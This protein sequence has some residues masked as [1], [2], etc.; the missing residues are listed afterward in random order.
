MNTFEQ[1]ER[2]KAAIAGVATLDEIYPILRSHIE[3]LGFKFFT[4]E[5]GAGGN[6]KRWISS[7][8]PEWRRHYRAN[9]YAIDDPV[10][11]YAPRATEP[12]AWTE[13]CGALTLTPRQRLLFDE[14]TDIGLRAGGAVPI[15]GSGPVEAYISVASDLPAV[16]FQELFN[17]NQ[18]ELSLLTQC[19]HAGALKLRDVLAAVSP[20]KL[21]KREVLVLILAALGKKQKQMVTELAI[22]PDTVKAHLENARRKLG[23]SNT[24]QAVAVAIQRRLIFP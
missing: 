8:P 15:H 17:M 11:L 4:Y 20:I 23:A 14:A 19:T 3:R 12:Y 6:L 2:Y 7:F 13:A 21:S 24:T 1:V 22:S 18:Q 5:V 16:E 10:C 9:C